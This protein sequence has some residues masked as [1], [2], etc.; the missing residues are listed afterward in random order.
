MLSR[1]ETAVMNVVYNLCK[2]K[3]VCIV[4]PEELLKMLPRQ[5][6]LTKQQLDGILSALSLDHYFDLL[7]S[8]RKGE[9]TYVICLKAQGFAFK[10][11]NLQQKRD[12]AFKFSWAIVSAVIAFIVGWLLKRIF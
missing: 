12:V 6:G 8:E 1:K 10:R 2:D 9:Q 4:S 7:T 5:K 3:G 11:C